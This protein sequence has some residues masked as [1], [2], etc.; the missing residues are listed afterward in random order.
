[1]SSASSVNDALAGYLAGRVTAEHLVSVVATEYYG[2]KERVG[3]GDWL[4]PMI[5][6]IDR[7]H[8]GV[9]ELRSIADSPGFVVGLQ[10][11]P[12]P[13]QWEAPLRDAAG[14]VAQGEGTAANH[15]PLPA[16]SLLTRILRTIRRIFRA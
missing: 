8:P 6:V 11:R 4:R 1:M 16:P 10:E 9:V 14:R 2:K 13:K 7:A 3:S 12:F 5:D 15:S